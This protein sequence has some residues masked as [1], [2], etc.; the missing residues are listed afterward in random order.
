MAP[1][2]LRA[3][4]IMPVLRDYSSPVSKPTITTSRRHAGPR[5]T[6]IGRQQIGRESSSPFSD[7]SGLHLQ[8]TAALERVDILRG[9][10]II[11]S[12]QLAAPATDGSLRLLWMGAEARGTAAD[13]RVNWN[14]ELSVDGGR[15]TSASPVNFH[16]AD[17]GVRLAEDGQRFRW[18]SATAGNRAGV[19]FH[20]EGPEDTVFTFN[21]GPCAFERTLEDFRRETQSFDAGASSVAR[22][23]VLPRMT[24][25]Q[26]MLNWSYGSRCPRGN[27]RCGYA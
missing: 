19:V 10:D 5:V 23:S 6:G 8:Q 16:S 4:S 3:T 7:V 18:T 9:T 22:K 25:Q 24:A 2:R 13:Q 17:D 15:L 21:T 1:V 12:H 14:G 20:F 11:E 27:R 26:Q